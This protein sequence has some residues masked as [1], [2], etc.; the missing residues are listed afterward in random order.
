MDGF[1]FG[2]C[3]GMFVGAATLVAAVDFLTAVVVP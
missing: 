2:F 3:I 1:L